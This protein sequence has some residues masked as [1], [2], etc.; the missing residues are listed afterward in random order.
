MPNRILLYVLI[1]QG[2]YYLAT[3]FW[4]VINLQSFMAFAGAKPDRFVFWTVDLLIIAI[5]ATVLFGAIRGDLVTVAFLGIASALS[6][7]TIEVAFYGKVSPWFL[8]DFAVEVIILL[9]IA[10]SLLASALQ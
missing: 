2:I 7:V 1:F 9:G 10:G 5:G 8:A 4:P 6:F 3:A